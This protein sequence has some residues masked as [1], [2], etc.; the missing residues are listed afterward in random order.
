MDIMVTIIS[1]E[2][3]KLIEE[4]KQTASKL[5][6]F[7]STEEIQYRVSNI[8]FL[9]ELILMLSRKMEDTNGNNI[10]G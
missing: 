4:I 1:D 5:N 3:A 7:D 10:G 8:K 9:S 2:I 6:S